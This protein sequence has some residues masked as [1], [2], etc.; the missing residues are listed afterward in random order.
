MLHEPGQYD[1][2]VPDIVHKDETGF[3][4]TTF[5]MHPGCHV[6]DADITNHTK[7]AQRDCQLGR[8]AAHHSYSAD[9][10]SVW[11]NRWLYS[12]YMVVQRVDLESRYDRFGFRAICAS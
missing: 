2:G 1:T 8:E 7:V 11:T 10:A 12:N 9:M 5:V 3:H 4:S 6:S